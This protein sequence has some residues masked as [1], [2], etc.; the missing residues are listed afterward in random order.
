MKLQERMESISQKFVEKGYKM[1][2][3]REATVRVLLEHENDH[4]SS[5]EIY[6]LVKG[7]YPEIGIATVYRSLE[8]LTELRIVEKMS[9]GKRV[10]LFDLR[11]EEQTHM[12]HHLICTVCRKM[13]EI[14]DDWLSELEERLERELGFKV[15]DHRLEF[16]GVYQNCSKSGCARKSGI[17]SSR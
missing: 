11:S 7:I 15:M 4:L 10:A 16:T 5:E 14:K 12:H 1:T 17:G 9:F 8:L 6:L 2:T 13:E 3:Q